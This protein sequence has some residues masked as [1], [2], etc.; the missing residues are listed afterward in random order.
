MAHDIGVVKFIGKAYVV[1]G[2]G[3]DCYVCIDSEETVGIVLMFFSKVDIGN[4]RSAA[5]ALNLWAG[6][7]IQ[8]PAVGIKLVTN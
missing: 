5:S 6:I 1:E 3:P 7:D 4:A 8:E 2:A